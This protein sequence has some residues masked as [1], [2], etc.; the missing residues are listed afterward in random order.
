MARGFLPFVHRWFERT[1]T[2][3]TRPQRE[4]WEAI[5]EGRDT[6]I[7]APTGSGEHVVAGARYVLMS[8]GVAEVA[9]AVTDAWQGRGLGK[10]L[11]KHLT[12]IAREAGLR[13]LR[14]E[15]MPG[16]GSML[17][18][19]RGSG[20]PISTKTEADAVHVRLLLASDAQRVPSA[21]DTAKVTP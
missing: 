1:F 21:A 2:E 16:N 15:V 10:L 14:A 3:A 9:F 19:F 11:M 17:A 12:A 20:L 13:E 8:P 5:A 7:V 4:G 18:V 6:L